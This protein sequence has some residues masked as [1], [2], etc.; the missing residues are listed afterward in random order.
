MLNS[1]PSH[2]AGSVVLLSL[3][4]CAPSSVDRDRQ[5]GAPPEAAT[6][7]SWALSG[8]LCRDEPPRHTAVRQLRGETVQSMPRAIR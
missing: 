7:D 6:R 1:R 5:T 3:A 2:V 8:R 4:A